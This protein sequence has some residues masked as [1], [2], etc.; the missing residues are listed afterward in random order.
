MRK[1]IIW[2]L[3]LLSIFFCFFVFL[4]FSGNRAYLA[5]DYFL[6]EKFGVTVTP[7]GMTAV[8][9]QERMG[10]NYSFR[11]RNVTLGK[12][13]GYDAKNQGLYLKDRYNRVMMFV[14]GDNSLVRDGD[15]IT[16]RVA[17]GKD[18][19]EKSFD[20]DE[21]EDFNQHLDKLVVL[22]WPSE[23]GRLYDLFRSIFKDYVY[24][25][26]GTRLVDSITIYEI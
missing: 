22:S 9:S 23:H 7:I 25:N 18:I 11:Y 20:V 26:Y 12:L 16:Y 5:V 3:L 8:K 24:V 17:T 2:A 4:V 13:V 1:V 19:R 10:D 15:V 6:Y 14:V 21:V